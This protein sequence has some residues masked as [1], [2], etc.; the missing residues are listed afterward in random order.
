MDIEQLHAVRSAELACILP[1]LAEL[2]GS[3]GT[4]EPRILELGSGT[5]WQARQLA[6]HGYRVEAIDIAASNYAEEQIWPITVY[7]GR[8]I[9]FPDAHF[10]VLLSSN[11]LE[12]IPHLAE[13]HDE[14]RRVIK[15]RGVALHLVPSGTWRLWTNLAHYPFVAKS[16]VRAVLARLARTANGTGRAAGGASASGGERA[17]ERAPSPARR[18]VPTLLRG[19]LLPAR[20]GETGN[21]L[22]EVY[23]FSRLGWRRLFERNGWTVRQASGNGL[24]YTGHMLFG[25]AVPHAARRLA[26]RV[27][28]GSCHVF[29][30]EKAGGRPARE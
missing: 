2:A 7:D 14:M 16:A 12:H 15:P 26:S 9:P 30:L 29:V 18:S 21:A 10:D 13:F 1:V 22:S 23:H 6:D 27:M 11:V 24:T 19:A 4:A 28:G 8:N 5:G 25:S 3:A 17:P 20:H